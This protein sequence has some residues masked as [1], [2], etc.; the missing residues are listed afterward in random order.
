MTET[1]TNLSPWQCQEPTK[2]DRVREKK[3][4]K[5]SC[6]SVPMKQSNR[7]NKSSMPIRN[8]MCPRFTFRAVNYCG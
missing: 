3:I 8:Y 6:E 5:W 4:I 7:V 1:I 2:E